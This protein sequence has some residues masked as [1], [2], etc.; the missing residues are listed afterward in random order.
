MIE[1]LSHRPVRPLDKQEAADVVVREHYLHRRPPMSYAFGLYD[2]CGDLVGVC[3]F[4]SPPSRELQKSVCPEAPHKVLELNRLW[5]ADY[6]PRNTESYFVRS[7]LKLLPA[8]IIVSYADTKEGHAGFIYR[9]ASFNY[10]GWTD[11]DRKTPRY[12]YHVEGR[13]SRDAFRGDETYTRIMRQPKVKYWTVT[14]NPKRRRELRR[15]C[16][17]PALDWKTNPPPAIN[18][19]V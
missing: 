1:F 2:L 7:C 4:G 13:H 12:D 5:V 17:W 3:T 6:M 11:M 8:F 15:L 14:G 9:A 10:S 16:A 19:A 18:D